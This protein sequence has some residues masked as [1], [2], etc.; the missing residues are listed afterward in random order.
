MQ[1]SKMDDASANPPP[2]YL[3]IVALV[4]HPPVYLSFLDDSP[5]C[6]P[7]NSENNVP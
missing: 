1:I 3:R 4:S 2:I 7:P 6:H 5:V